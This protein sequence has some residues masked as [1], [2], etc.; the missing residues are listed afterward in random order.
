[1]VKNSEADAVSHGGG[2]LLFMDCKH[3]MDDGAWLPIS[4]ALQICCASL[5]IVGPMR[6]ELGDGDEGVRC[7]TG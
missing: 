1:M 2:V 7:I 3:G 5:V 6:G 4:D